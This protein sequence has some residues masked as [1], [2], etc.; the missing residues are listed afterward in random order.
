MQ[1]F[2]I[3]DLNSLINALCHFQTIHGNIKVDVVV[4]LDN[5][6]GDRYA[7]REEATTE[8]QA[9]RAMMPRV[10]ME[11]VWVSDGTVTLFGSEN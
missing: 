4:A 9:A 5:Q 10:A 7:M 6:R 3:K 1:T 2:S 11:T 8:T